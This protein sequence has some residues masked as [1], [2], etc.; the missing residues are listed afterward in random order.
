ML[1]KL[2]R[3]D[4]TAKA[5]THLEE[6]EVECAKCDGTGR[7]PDSY[8]KHI[9]ECRRCEG[10]GK[11]DWVTNVMGRAGEDYE[12]SFSATSTSCSSSS[13]SFRL[14]RIK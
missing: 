6:G 10:T 1:A 14:R 13:Q 4:K 2:F 8:F 9:Y 11:T 3:S 5:Y 12:S 7:D